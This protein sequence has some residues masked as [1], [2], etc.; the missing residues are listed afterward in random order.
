MLLR[1][2]DVDCVMLSADGQVMIC[3]ACVAI[4]VC[5]MDH[6]VALPH[7]GSRR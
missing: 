4:V 5:L 1:S 2:E 6:A 3:S 7:V